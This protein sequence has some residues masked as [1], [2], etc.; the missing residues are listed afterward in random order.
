MKRLS[1]GFTLVEIIVTVSII[2]ILASVIYANFNDGSAQSRDAKRKADLVLLQNAIELYKNDNGRYPAGCNGAGVWSGQASTNF[3]CSS[4][5]QYIVGLAPKY[6]RV[7]PTDPRIG[8]AESNGSGALAADSGYMY[9][10]NAPG[11]VYKLVARN[12]VETETLNYDSDFKSCDVIQVQPGNALFQSVSAWSV[13]PSGS[14]FVTEYAEYNK[15][16]YAI[17]NVIN[18]NP[19]CT[20]QN[21]NYQDLNSSASECKLSDIR[22]SYGVWGGYGD[23]N[24]VFS[25]NSDEMEVECLT[26]QII[27]DMP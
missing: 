23:P 3:A 13:C 27:C 10:T 25:N 2:A 1:A 5:S 11:T 9:L 6:I 14:E 19:S 22:Y 24:D 18:V 16:S 8:A 21:S 17:C 15:C 4:G 20:K 26:E 12:T 7:L